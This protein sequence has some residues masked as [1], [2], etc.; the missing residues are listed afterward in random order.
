[1]VSTEAC[2]LAS[3]GF[4]FWWCRHFTKYLDNVRWPK[5]SRWWKQLNQDHEN[6]I[7]QKTYGDFH[8]QHHEWRS[9]VVWWGHTKQPNIRNKNSIL[10]CF[11]CQWLCQIG[12]SSQ[13]EITHTYIT[14]IVKRRI[15]KQKT[16]SGRRKNFY[17]ERKVLSSGMCWFAR[18][19]QFQ[20]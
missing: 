17:F 8:I 1:M 4:L 3:Q 10:E 19:G 18:P 20:I 14:Y 16:L 7:R 12:L 13:Q 11:Q 5:A 9:G 6:F 2:K 15:G